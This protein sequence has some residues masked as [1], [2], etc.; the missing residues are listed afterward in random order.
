MPT[1]RKVRSD[2]KLERLS[3][4]QHEQLICWLD[5]ENCSYTEAVT[6]VH[7]EFGLTV[8]RTA[9]VA[10]YQRH[11]AP[12]HHPLDVA[13][14]AAF[15]ELPEGLFEEA[16]IK[17][18]R[19]L[20]WSA[21]SQPTP[22]IQ[23]ASAMLA[24]VHQAD[25]QAIAEQRLKLDTRRVVVREKE[26]AFRS[27]HQPPDTEAGMPEPEASPDHA[28]LSEP[29]RLT[30]PASS[31]TTLPEAPHT[32]A[33]AVLPPEP[34][35]TEAALRNPPLYSPYF[36]LSRHRGNTQITAKNPEVIEIQLLAEA[37]AA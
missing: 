37:H 28:P 15:S 9:M 6:R 23:T 10:Y 35:S 17:M 30:S 20:A 5:E 8:G 33:A 29:A 36:G 4:A 16:T 18:A 1:R 32:A 27:R 11:V 19:R 31:A 22:Q 14:A 26:A 34:L 7:Q 24:L 3:A 2:A 21:I 13:T 12:L 25:R